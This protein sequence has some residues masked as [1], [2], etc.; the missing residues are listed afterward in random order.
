LWWFISTINGNTFILV[1]AHS[2]TIE[3]VF[4]VQTQYLSI[5]RISHVLI[6]DVIWFLR[7]VV[8]YFYN[9]R[10]YFY[11]GGGSFTYNQNCF[12]S[13]DSVH[14]ELDKYHITRDLEIFSVVS[15]ILYN[16]IFISPNN[17]IY[18]VLYQCEDIL[19]CQILRIGR[20]QEHCITSQNMGDSFY[21]IFTTNIL[22][23][24]T[25]FLWLHGVGIH[26]VI[27][28]NYHMSDIT[29]ISRKIC[30]N[31]SLHHFRKHKIEYIPVS[32]Q[33]MISLILTKV[34]YVLKVKHHHNKIF[35]DPPTTAYHLSVRWSK[36]K[37]SEKWR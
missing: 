5:Y 1:V 34:W 20:F 32:L 9:K 3:T 27:S 2:L 30:D 18:C 26:N 24:H 25:L 33:R 21:H 10:Q 28:K 7:L 11:F 17:E 13:S 4:E 23:S 16:K 19:T 29:L 14:N 12:W 36:Q 8:I 22:I 31:M 15:I 37:K 6:C 35:L